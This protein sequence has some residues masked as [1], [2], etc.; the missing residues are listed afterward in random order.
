M[1]NFKITWKGV[2][3]NINIKNL[4]S[5]IQKNLSCN[6][7]KMT[8]NVEI[9]NIFNKKTKNK[10]NPSA[11]LF[12]DFLKNRTQNSFFL[13]P[14]NKSAIRNI[15]SSLDLNR[16]AG[17]N[18]ISTKIL[19]LLKNDISSRLADIFNISFSTGVFPTILKVFKVVPVYK[20]TPN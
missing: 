6:G 4:S 18:I 5:D 2:K 17:S 16:L 13:S 3:S 12:S 11:K 14:T 9:S 8:R 1:K 19:K 15:T 20:K 10:N 7:F